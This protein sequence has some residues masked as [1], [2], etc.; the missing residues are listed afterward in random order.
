MI[1]VLQEYQKNENAVQ[2]RRTTQQNIKN[3]TQK[4]MHKKEGRR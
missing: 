1:N 4:K 3:M 2:V